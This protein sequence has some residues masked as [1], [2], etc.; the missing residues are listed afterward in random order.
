MREKI[1][2]ETKQQQQQKNEG[3]TP[4]FPGVQFNSLPT[5][6]HALLS[7]RLETAASD[8]TPV[9]GITPARVILTNQM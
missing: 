4:R 1:H 9:Y 7:E 8:V 5:D 3:R 2:V 6:R